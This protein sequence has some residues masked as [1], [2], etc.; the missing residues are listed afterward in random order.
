MKVPLHLSRQWSRLYIY[1]NMNVIYK[2]VLIKPPYHC[3]TGW[4]AAGYSSRIITDGSKTVPNH[5]GGS[6]NLTR[7]SRELRGIKESQNI[8]GIGIIIIITIVFVYNIVKIR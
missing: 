7:I 1:G 2:I 5:V 6:E 8:D 3:S 4:F